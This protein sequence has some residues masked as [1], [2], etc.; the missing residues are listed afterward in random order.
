MR[1]LFLKRSWFVRNGLVAGLAAVALSTALL[2]RACNAQDTTQVKPPEGVRLKLEYA[3]SKPSILVLPVGG[4]AGDSV[5]AIVQRDL[6]FGDR[7]GVYGTTGAT[8]M[9]QDA[10]GVFNYPLYAK[11]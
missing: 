2:S 8:P 4:A 1:K 11:L 10:K 3:G 6:E 9:A 5:R 7:I